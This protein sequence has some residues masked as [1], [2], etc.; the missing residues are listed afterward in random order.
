MPRP[1]L[2]SPRPAAV[3]D[4]R[5]PGRLP[6]PRRAALLA[7]AAC[8]GLGLVAGGAVAAPASVPGPARPVADP[9]VHSAPDAALSVLPLGSFATGVFDEGAAE[10]VAFHAGTQR[11]FVVNAQ[12]GTVDV[13]DASD[14]TAPTLLF[15]L[16]ADGVA[17]SVAVRPDG[18]GVIALEAPTKT[19]PGSLVFFDARAA[20][21]RVLGAVQVGA[22]PDMVALAPDGR[23]AVVA[24]EG[25]PS[26]DYAVDPEGSISVVDLPSAVRAPAQGSVR[27]A[28]FHH[29]EDGALPDG[30]RVFAGIEGVD[31]PVSR[32]LEPE[33][34]TVVGT[35]AYATLQEADAVAVVDLDAARVTA[36]LPLGTKDHGLAGAGLDPSDR[37]GLAGP[38]EVPGLQGL[39]QPDGIAAYD[40]DGTTY[41][42]TANEGDA[43]EWGDYAEPV[44]VKDLGDEGVPPLCADSPLAALT[45][46]ADLGRLHVSRASGLRA[47]G[48]CYEELLA[49]GGR[50]FSVWTTDGT[51]V[52]DS[53]D[54]L[55]RV[56][57]EALPAAFN[58]SH[59]STALDARSDDK[60]P[61]P[62]NLVIGEVDGRTYVFVGLERVGG[63][64]AFD[65]TDPAAPTFVTYVNNRDLAVSVDDAAEE[66]RAEALAAAGDL[67]PE[68]LAFIPASDSPTGSPLLAVGNE[69]SGT[70]TLLAVS[71]TD[72][73]DVA[74]PTS[75][76]AGRDVPV[77]LSGLAPHQVVAVALDGGVGVSGRANPAGRV[78]LHLRPARSDTGART[79]VVTS[80][81]HVAVELPLEVR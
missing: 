35:T 73:V 76:R 59:T 67:G 2:P 7:V 6:G 22:L 25:E 39:Y 74:L 20:G 8:G 40:V 43:R 21:P 31:L 60:G 61:E 52:A 18:L 36:V 26:E 68:G 75:V 54:A 79:V 48:T 16:A 56:T 9:V 23:R 63:V 45:S 50:S 5:R 13:L 70:T 71:P 62:E 42:V 27:I 34:V 24:N 46:D 65:V 80:P 11:L 66:D 64:A 32:N 33:Y 57:A 53:G 41:L 81:G 69:V 17:N 19:D 1:A 58:T 49:F 78:T 38:R 72:W 30:V 55:E 37:D 29:L 47:D 44:R 15:S 10:I 77:R 12:A 51:L 3:D 14:P 4:A 28:D